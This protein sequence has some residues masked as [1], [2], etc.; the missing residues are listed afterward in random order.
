MKTT[1]VK[2]LITSVILKSSV[3][4]KRQEG[5]MLIFNMA[6][7]YFMKYTELLHPENK[8]LLLS[9]LSNYLTIILLS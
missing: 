9:Y 2:S 8:T 1:F 6:D 4:F 7:Y 5:N 3:L